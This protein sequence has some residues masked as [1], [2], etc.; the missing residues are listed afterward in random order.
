M[1]TQLMKISLGSDG[2]GTLE[3]G[4]RSVLCGGKPDYKY[5]RDLTI[6]TSDKEISHT[7]RLG[8]TPSTQERYRSRD[9]RAVMPFSLRLDGTNG[10]FIHEWPVLPGSHGCIHLLPDDA[11]AVYNWVQGRTRVLI[12][13]K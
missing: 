1:A 8:V 9:G 2:L 10:I 11:E 6:N 5:P 4:G 12:T 13:Q 7:S 3:F